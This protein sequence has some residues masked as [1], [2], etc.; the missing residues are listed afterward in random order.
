MNEQD[1]SRVWKNLT[2][3]IMQLAAQQKGEAGL[4]S[5]LAQRCVPNETY[6]TIKLEAEMVGIGGIKE[7]RKV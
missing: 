4:S 6:C 5:M 2:T 3:Q 1:R 7:P